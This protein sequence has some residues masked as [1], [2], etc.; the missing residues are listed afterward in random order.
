MK[1]VGSKIYSTVQDGTIVVTTNGSTYSINAK[2]FIPPKVNPVPSVT[3]PVKETIHQSL[4][5][6]QN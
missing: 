6:S 3:E 2:E 1:A 5:H 4:S